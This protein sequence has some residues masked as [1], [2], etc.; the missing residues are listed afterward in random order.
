MPIRE[1]L[2]CMILGLGRLAHSR[3]A[4]D[5]T[6]LEQVSIAPL[7][8][9]N[10]VGSMTHPHRDHHVKV[11]LNPDAPADRTTVNATDRAGR[12][13][14]SRRLTTAYTSR[15]WRTRWTFL[16]APANPTARSSNALAAA[17]ATTP[18]R[19]GGCSPGAPD[20]PHS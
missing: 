14:R 5:R 2:I 8:G 3:H 11:K 17:D 20:Q 15:A 19:G 16:G 4:L 9:R 10:D 6:S 7:G 12:E 18:Q 13:R 1:G